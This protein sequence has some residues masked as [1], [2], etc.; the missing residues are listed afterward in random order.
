VKAGLPSRTAQAAAIHRAAHQLVDKP[1]VF[2]D[3]LALRILGAEDEA[4]LRAG[5]PA[6][7][8][9]GSDFM[10]TFVAVRSRFAEEA[11]EAAYRAGVRQYVVLGAGLDTFAY[12]C[13]LEGLRVY[14]VDHPATQ[15]WKRERLMG[16]GIAV[17]E[18]VVYVPLDFEQETLR[19]GLARAAFEGARPAFY[20]WLG[21]TPYLTPEA[22]L[23]TLAAVA[24]DFAP[25]S[26]I[27]FDFAAPPCDHP[28]A[29]AARRALA[30]R[31]EALGEP[32]LSAFSPPVLA[33]ELRAMGY[34]RVDVFGPAALE[35]R[36][37][38]GRTDGLRLRGGHLVLAG[39]S[40]EA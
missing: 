13:P 21:V 12:R 7:A 3:P 39:T 2:E 8:A 31:V 18:R 38:A 36:Y 24:R 15:V 27:A 10:R 9:A 34:T 29:R 14:E 20:A 1:P 22:V 5:L 35:A 40:H 6:A 25:G 19:E 17:P 23:A 37:L 28:R 33:A 4:A 26:E 11:L 16:C 30:A 32:L